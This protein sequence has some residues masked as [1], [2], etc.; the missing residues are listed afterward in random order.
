MKTLEATPPA[1]GRGA[2][3][4]ASMRPLRKAA[5]LYA[6]AVVGGLALTGLGMKTIEYVGV[7]AIVRAPNTGRASF[8]A[9]PG[10]LHLEVGPPAATLALAIMDAPSPRGTVFVLHGIRDSKESMRGW[11]DM[12]VGAGYRAVLVD[13][14]GQGH[15]TGDMLTYGVQESA[16]LAQ[17][18]T[19]LE[20][21]ELVVG[22]VGIMGN[23]YGAATAIQWA[24]RDARIRAVIAVSPFASLRDVVPG[25]GILPLPASFAN[26]IIALAGER[27]GFDPDAASAVDAITHTTAPVLLIHGR[28]DTRIP[29]WHSQHIRAAGG[30]HAELVLIDGEGHETVGGARETRLADRMERWFGEYLK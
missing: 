3:P 29:F 15:S 5:L 11:G 14:R 4:A 12:L 17:V 28:S 2:R 18:L 22:P 19:S 1:E 16:D 25:Y 24:G 23:S 21:Q 13:L 7:E 26:R 27:G 20:A 9:A 10:E 30:D 8:P 6:A